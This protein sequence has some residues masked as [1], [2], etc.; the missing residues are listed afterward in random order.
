MRRVGR[1]ETLTATNIA[2][3]DEFHTG[4]LRSTRELAE[5]AGFRPGISVLDIGCGLGG[6]ARVLAAEFGSHVTGLDFTPEFIRSGRLL[7][8]KC[9][10]DLRVTF[11]EGDALEMPFPML[12]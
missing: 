5:L 3:A 4:G 2:P 1:L 8:E 12:S 6:P 7:T 10:L 9:G 11:V